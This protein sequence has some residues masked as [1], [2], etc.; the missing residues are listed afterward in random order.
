MK[1]AIIAISEYGN[2]KT[3][4]NVMLI[5]NDIASQTIWIERNLFV[6]GFIV[7]PTSRIMSES[8]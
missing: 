8:L 5:A 1:T 2:L 6:S 7:I 3:I 4:D